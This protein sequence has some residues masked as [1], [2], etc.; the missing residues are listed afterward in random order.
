MD[1]VCNAAIDQCHPVIRP[2]LINA[3]GKT[4]FDQSGVEQVAGIVAGK[5][6]PGAIGPLQSRRK[7]NNHKP[8]V[9]DRRNQ[10]PAR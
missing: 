4:I 6:A 10:E 1:C 2:G 3:F 7:A 9:F 8:S 5:R